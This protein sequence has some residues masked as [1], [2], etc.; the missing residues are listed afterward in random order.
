MF[1]SEHG[2]PWCRVRDATD[3]GVRPSYHN[4]GSVSPPSPLDNIKTVVTRTSQSGTVHGPDQAVTLD[5]ALRAQTIDAAF[6]LGR[7]HEL[8]S[9]EVGKFADFAQLNVD[10]HD[11]D[12]LQLGAAVS[13]KGTW[14]GG[15]RIDL[16]A[17]QTA[18][19]VADPSP[20]KHLAAVHPRCC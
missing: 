16:E 5:E 11:V 3:A 14:L 20:H 19:G 10:P 4:D 17:F 18:A 8:G 2:A 9:I 13:V 12:P 7:E 15:E 1:D 6:I